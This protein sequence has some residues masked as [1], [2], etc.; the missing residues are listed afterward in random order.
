MTTMKAVRVY[1]YGGPEVLV[2][3]DAPKPEPAADEI[4]VRVKA[5][6]VNPIDWKIREGQTKAWLNYQMPFIPGS[7][8]AGVVEEVGSEITKFKVGDEVFAYPGLMRGGSYADFAII[9]EAETAL[10]PKSLDFIHA[11]ALV[12]GPLTA[13]QA[14]ELGS[15][16]A[17]QKV[18]AHAAAGGVGSAAVQLAKIRGA[19]V[20][21]TASARNAEFVKDLGADEVID[22][23]ATPFEEVVQNIDLVFDLAGGLTQERSYSV[24]KKGGAMIT[25]VHPPTPGRDAEYGVKTAMVVVQPNSAQLAQFA[26]WADEGR[27]KPVVSTVLP[28][29]EAR[30]AQELSQTGHVRGKI[31]LQS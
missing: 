10:K 30:Q 29:N 24:L 12:V 20:I 27:L 7:E 3:E 26:A 22:Y 28:L 23:T 15:L 19:Y 13:W 31:V 8:V 21:G 17:G 11:V 9:K 1:E 2:Y 14:F 5:R 18:L 6:G 25:A 4:L 16:Q